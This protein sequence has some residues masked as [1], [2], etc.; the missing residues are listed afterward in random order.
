MEKNAVGSSDSI[1]YLILFPPQSFL[2]PKYR[3]F[4][5]NLL[6]CH[7]ILYIYI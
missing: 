5:R 2:T 7:R 6:F 3:N 4:K 1:E